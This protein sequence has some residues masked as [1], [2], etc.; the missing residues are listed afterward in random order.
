MIT[1][2]EARTPIFQSA[3]WLERRESKK[4]KLV[5]KLKPQKK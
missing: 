5:K 3:A 1:R 4:S 2:K